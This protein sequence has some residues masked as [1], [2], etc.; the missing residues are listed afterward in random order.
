M[1]QILVNCGDGYTDAATITPNQNIRTIVCSVSAP[2]FAV[3]QV[4][5]RMVGGKPQFDQAEQAIQPGP[6]TFTNVY[7]IRFRN[8]TAGKVAVIQANAYFV[9]E[10]VPEG[11]IPSSVVFTTGGSTGGGLTSNVAPTPLASFPPA[12]PAD[13]DICV[14][15]LPATYDPVGGKKMRWILQYNAADAVWDFL[16]GPDLYAVIVTQEAS[17][18]TVYVD[19]ATVGPSITL[20]R[21]GDYDITAEFDVWNSGGTINGAY[22]MGYAIGGSAPSDATAAKGNGGNT[23]NGPVSGM[24]RARNL[25]LVITNVITAKYRLVNGNGTGEYSNRALIATPVRIT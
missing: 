23:N 10:A 14:L 16:G 13:G 9:G 12:S 15:E 22:N 21:P 20:P 1:L 17:A 4:A 25:G 5:N 24:K 6:I 3:V 19:L 11:N 8:F 2:N 18:S 7:G